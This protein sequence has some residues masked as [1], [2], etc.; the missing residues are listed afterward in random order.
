VTNSLLKAGLCLF[1]ALCSLQSLCAEPAP[2]PL[3][4]DFVGLNGHSC[5]FKPE[6]Y[7]PVCGVVRDY[8]PVDWDLKKGETGTLPPWPQARNGVSW[9]K[10]YGSWNKAGL[11]IDACLQF[12]NM[13]SDWKDLAHDAHEYAKTFAQNFGPGGKWPT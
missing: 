6:L 5:V 3:F 9:E 8:H 7:K 13:K 12:D 2:R 4:R 1:F 11:R 10:E